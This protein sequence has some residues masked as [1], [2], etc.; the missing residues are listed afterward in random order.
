ME[1][2]W[3][4][5]FK[6]RFIEFETAEIGEMLHLFKFDSE[7]NDIHFNKNDWLIKNSK[8]IC[9]N[10]ATTL[11]NRVKGQRL[12]FSEELHMYSLA[13]IQNIHINDL[14]RDFDISASTIRRIIKKV[15][16][17][18][19]C[20]WNKKPS[21]RRLLME[22]PWIKS[23]VKS[24]FS[25][26]DN[27]K[28]VDDVWKY[29]YEKSGI[30]MPAHLIRQYIKDKLN[31]SYKIGKSRPSILEQD[32]NMLIKW[33]FSV[34]IAQILPRIKVIAN[35]DEACFS[36]TLK[37][38]RSWI[39]KGE[40]GVLTNVKYSGTISIISCITDTGWT[41]NATVRGTINSQV[42][43]DYFKEL[44][45]FMKK[46]QIDQSKILIL[47]DNASSHRAKCVRD[48]A[49]SWGVNIAFLPPYCPEMAPVEKF[50]GI[51]KCLIR[52]DKTYS[53]MNWNKHGVHFIS[54]WVRKI[55]PNIIAK[56]WRTFTKEIQ[57]YLD[58]LYSLF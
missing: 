33:Y 36:H 50:F 11:M 2:I 17:G 12:S 56:I 7:N 49:E 31:L 55:D 21:T 9:P 38:K 15:E 18:D 45:N 20:K 51:L 14:A 24:F 41:F 46:Q 48:F 52:K 40:E 34:R 35:I 32:K 6:D 23:V 58:H 3:R 5:I 8:E 53:T 57:Y 4:L 27:P 37:N 1:I 47:L 54:D 28:T 29:V 10:A 30:K 19:Q 44:M 42:F 26:N 16:K 43:L 25:L 13:K 39:K 22:S